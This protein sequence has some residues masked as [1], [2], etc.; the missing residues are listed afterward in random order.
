MISSLSENTYNKYAMIASNM[1][2]GR[3]SAGP[4]P[5]AMRKTN[6]AMATAMMIPAISIL[7]DDDETISSSRITAYI[8]DV[9]SALQTNCG[10]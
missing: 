5:A 10:L 9:A 7:I 2:M 1:Y 8:L 3:T 6:G 4:D